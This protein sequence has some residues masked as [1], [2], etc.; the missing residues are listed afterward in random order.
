M[1]KD[2]EESGR[3]KNRNAVVGDVP[4]QHDEGKR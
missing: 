3:F 4:N 2:G 1:K